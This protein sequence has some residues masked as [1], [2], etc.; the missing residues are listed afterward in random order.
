MIGQAQSEVDDRRVHESRVRRGRSRTRRRRPNRRITSAQE[1]RPGCRAVL[2]EP[3]VRTYTMESK[4]RQI[5]WADEALDYP[6][7]RAN[8]S[9]GHRRNM[10]FAE[11]AA[12]LDASTHGGG[13]AHTVP[14][15]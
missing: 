15:A 8:T 14:A 9:L 13:D 12:V 6:R 1:R 3:S 11:P 10:P 5:D 7:M 2:P 4:T